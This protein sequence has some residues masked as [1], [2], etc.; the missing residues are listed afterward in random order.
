MSIQQMILN[1]YIE[2]RENLSNYIY[3]EWKKAEG[4]WKRY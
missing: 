2:E 3:R 4:I 1:G